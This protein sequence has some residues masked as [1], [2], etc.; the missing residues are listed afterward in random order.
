MDMLCLAG[1]LVFAMT[2]MMSVEF[3]LSKGF[4]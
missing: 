2:I 1:Y 3:F 4:L